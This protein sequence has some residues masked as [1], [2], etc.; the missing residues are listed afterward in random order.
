MPPMEQKGLD[1]GGREALSAGE[2]RP[3]TRR[4]LT[5][6]QLTDRIQGLV[7]VE[8]FDVWVEGEI[9]NLK[10][11]GSGHWYFSLKDDGAQIRAVA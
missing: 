1:F 6:S 10:V 4:S 7:E 5:V 11:V 2:Q 8:F 9:S 3:A